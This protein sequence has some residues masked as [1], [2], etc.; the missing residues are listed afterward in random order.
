MTS[1]KRR[2]SNS[3]LRVVSDASVSKLRRSIWESSSDPTLSFH[4]RDSVTLNVRSKVI[5][6]GLPLSRTGGPD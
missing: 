4:R 5:I 3:R 2:I 1:M 6:M